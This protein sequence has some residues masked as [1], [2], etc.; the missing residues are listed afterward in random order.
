[1]IRS[2]VAGFVSGYNALAYNTFDIVQGD[3]DDVW[4][5]LKTYC[6][7]NVSVEIIDAVQAYI[8]AAW[9]QRQVQEPEEVIPL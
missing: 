8:R 1:V 7:A 3:L 4:R 6:R 2:W 9:D 5:W